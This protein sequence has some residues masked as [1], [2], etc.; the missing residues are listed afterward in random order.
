MCVYIY[1]YIYIYGSPAVGFHD[2]NLRN[3]SLRVSNPNKF[4]VDVFFDTMSD[5]NVPGSRA[6]KHGEI[7]EI[8]RRGDL[9]GVQKGSAPA[10]ERRFM[11]GS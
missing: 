8:D 5:F 9:N 2:F 1:I 11:S 6:T 3:F 4:F 7:S 10:R